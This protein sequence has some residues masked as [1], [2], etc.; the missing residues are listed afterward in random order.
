MYKSRFTQWGLR[1]NAKRKRDGDRESGREKRPIDRCSPLPTEHAGYL[2]QIVSA[3]TS[4]ALRSSTP[5]PR[6]V[7]TPPILAIPERILGVIGDYFRGSF[8]AGTWPSHN[9]LG[10]CHISKPAEHASAYLVHFYHSCIIACRLFDRKCFQDAGKML[11]SA[12]ARIKEILLAEEPRTLG[13]I[14]QLMLLVSLAGRHEIALIILRYFSTMAMTVL[15]DRHPMSQISWLLCSMDQSYFEDIA[16]RGLSSIYHNFR[17]LIGPMHYTTLAAHTESISIGERPEEKMRGLL[18][19]CESDLGLLKCRT[20]FVHVRLS[21]ICYANHN[22]IEAERLGQELLVRS[23]KLQW[24]IHK[25]SYRAKGLHIIAM[26][27]YALGERQ[28]A[29]SHILEAIALISPIEPSR[30]VYWLSILEGWLL[31]QGQEDSATKTRE[32]RW[33]LEESIN[34]PDGDYSALPI[35]VRTHDEL[36]NTH[37]EAR[38]WINIYGRRRGRHLDTLC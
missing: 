6:P 10:Y 18:G 21:F 38:R 31:E 1:K 34:P 23:R 11:I 19:E 8:E 9:G 36:R 35:S 32:R 24:T 14:F 16:A 3:K 30:A 4:R 15:G 2:A 7:M 22:Y 27:Q 37:A 33:K 26:S 25:H 5:L 12:T 20:T 17:T 29:K 13:K 28:S